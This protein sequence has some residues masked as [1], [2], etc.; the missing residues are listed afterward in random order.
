M[1]KI[2][3]VDDQNFTRQALQAL[4]ETEPDF[5]IVGQANN[6]LQAFEYMDQ[7][8]TDI[9][10]ADL[11]MPEMNGLTL[12]KIASQRF[13]H[14]KA[15]ILS[16]HDDE[17]NIN[18]AVEAGARGYLLKST[19]AQEIVD[20]I[21][22]VQRGYF[23]LGPGLFEKLLSHLIS[24]KAN[25][26]QNI[27][28][29]EQ[30]YREDLIKLKTKIAEENEKDRRELYNEIE[31][32]INSLKFEFRDGLQNFQYQVSNQLQTGLD[33]ANNQFNQYMPDAKKLESQIDERNSEQQKYINTLFVGTKQSLRKLERQVDLIRYCV[34]FLIF[35]F[36]VEK[37]AL[38]IF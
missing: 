37:L 15:I 8:S 38:V 9:L 34:V 31:S 1:I 25:Y 3:I 30:K 32:E 12:T 11:E 4:L 28:N 26:R 16:S 24:E 14:T 17:K 6:G 22:A 36:I 18:A 2:L 21:R 35:A 5:E 20:T 7:I 19:S 27:S 29:L 23:Q 10:I 33:A 13:P